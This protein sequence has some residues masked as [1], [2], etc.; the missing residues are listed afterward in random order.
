MKLFANVMGEG[1][2]LIVMHGVFGMSDNWQSLARKWQGKYRVHL[3]DLRNHGRSPHSEDASLGAMSDDLLQ[4]LDDHKIE[5][6]FILGHSLGGRIAM[7]FATAHPE[8]TAKLIVAD[9]APREYQPH[10]QSVIEALEQ[11]DPRSVSSR[12]EAQKEFGKQLDQA[13][14][15][16]LLKSLYWQDDKTLGWRFNWPVL[17]E[18]LS[19]PGGALNE[20][21]S[22]DGPAL[23]IR[24]GASDYVR[25]EDRDRIARHF[26]QAE[27]KTIDGAGHWLH[28]QE[29]QQFRALTESFLEA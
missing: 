19:K 25:D 4:C 8:R 13:T 24:G 26:P 10:H 22:Y 27:V 17:A 12:S 7:H 5:S 15:Q 6:A 16:F 1:D 9:I 2:D 21:Q 18:A 11:F 23:F 20:D 3:L 14:K 28:A 29:P